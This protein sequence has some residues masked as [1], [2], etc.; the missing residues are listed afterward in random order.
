VRER[1]WVLPVRD[2][3]LVLKRAHVLRLQVP[4]LRQRHR[5]VVLLPL[6]V[7]GDK[8]GTE[9]IMTRGMTVTSRD[10]WLAGSTVVIGAGV[11]LTLSAAGMHGGRWEIA[12]LTLLALL[13]GVR[14]LRTD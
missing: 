9:M 10:R 4:P 7:M 5:D 11:G 14:G 12:L 3:L 8:V 6:G 2:V 13:G 1:H